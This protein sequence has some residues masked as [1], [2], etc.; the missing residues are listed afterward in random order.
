MIRK[1]ISDTYCVKLANVWIV[2]AISVRLRE[3]RSFGY[4]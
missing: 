3:A 4:S 2:F 1:M